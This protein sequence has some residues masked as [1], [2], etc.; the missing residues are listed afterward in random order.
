MA[1][2][3]KPQV[4]SVSTDVTGFLMGG[5]RLTILKRGVAERA[6]PVGSEPFAIGRDKSCVI[7]I[8]D[9][10]SSK[11]HARIIPKTDRVLVQDLESR[12]GTRVNEHRM[13]MQMLYPGD[14]VR[15][16]R[17]CMI[18]LTDG[19]PVKRQPEEV[20][21]WLQCCDPGGGPKLPVCEIPLLFG[22]APEADQT[23]QGA[24]AGHF[25]MQIISVP[26]GAQAMQLNHEMPRIRLL[27]DGN[28]ITIGR[29][30]FVF[31]AIHG[32]VVQPSSDASVIRMLEEE[33]DRVER[34]VP[35]PGMGQDPAAMGIVSPHRLGG[36][37]V[38]ATRG[39]LVGK[40][41]AITDHTL[42]F[43]SDP[44]CD[45]VIDNRAVAKRHARIRRK[46]GEPML[47]DISKALGVYV[48]GQRI[49]THPLK[50]GDIIQIATDE[51][52]VH[53]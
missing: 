17:T 28:E 7:S 45:I 47:E 13:V 1:F 44:G 52:M 8:D 49:R 16:G 38:T 53:L 46:E 27:S 39:A 11:F 6:F 20:A 22:R 43:G 24:D 21:G 31:R 26:G 35:L 51:F 19:M 15:V 9:H 14:V 36:C 4:A 50:P 18:F 37:H 23:V 12:N 25:H 40:T 48:N 2:G 32:E 30:K 29:R 3:R 41:F 33:A 42:Y 5:R 10:L 34:Q